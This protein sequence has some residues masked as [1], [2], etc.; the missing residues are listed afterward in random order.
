MLED[1]WEDQRAF[2]LLLRQP[3]TCNEELA[4]Q[5]RDM[6]TWTGSELYELLR[7][8]PWKK[9]RR[10]PVLR[11]D[12][13]IEEEAIDIF[14]YAISILQLAGIESLEQLEQAYWRKTAVVRQ[15]YQEEWVHKIDRSCV[16]IDIDN[17]ICDYVGG[18]LSWLDAHSCIPKD[19]VEHL[20]AC[21]SYL[22]ASTVGLPQE[23][24]QRLKHHFRTQ[25]AKRG[26][27]VFHEAI[28]F[29][30]RM[31]ADGHLIILLTSR[32][33]DR[34]PNIFTDTIL[35]LNSHRLPYDYVWWS[36]DK[37]ERL[38]EL[39]QFVRFAVDDELKFVDQ[40]AQA[41][42]PTYWL[43]RH[44]ALKPHSSPMVTVVTSLMDVDRD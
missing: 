35:W 14:K 22:N 21:G 42:I 40:F 28:P 16:V 17:V 11:N 44:G 36:H 39:Q 2:N 30:F 31:R 33:I 9:H 10:V 38:A 29:L 20:R 26:L 15:R 12:A 24:W 8:T 6:V 25:G 3:P 18:L 32:P 23:L 34:Y 1:I 7:A 19:H 5:I 41:G 13:H 43:Q 37:A 27:P 4:E